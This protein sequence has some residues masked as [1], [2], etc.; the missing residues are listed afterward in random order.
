MPS[1]P[2]VWYIAWGAIPAILSIL[3]FWLTKSQASVSTKKADGNENTPSKPISVLSTLVDHPLKHLAIN[4]TGAVALFFLLFVMMN[5]I[6]TGFYEK[7]SNWKL[8]VSFMDDKG[9][10]IPCN[11]LKL[12]EPIP[13]PIKFEPF[14]DRTILVYLNDLREDNSKLKLNYSLRVT[15]DG[16]ETYTIPLEDSINEKLF[17][18][19]NRGSRNIIMKPLLLNTR[20]PG[21]IIPPTP[22]SSKTVPAPGTNSN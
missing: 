13:T 20:M 22:D 17:C 21:I 2:L 1:S 14:D 8:R 3:L 7:E 5:P 11:R 10:R 9:G 19:Q 16:Y 15:F 4:L 18:E 12:I 6:K